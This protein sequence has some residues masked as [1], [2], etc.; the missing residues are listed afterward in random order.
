MLRV[1]RKG[2]RDARNIRLERLPDDGR[3]FYF[4]PVRAV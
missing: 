4:V 3:R 2:F 1:R